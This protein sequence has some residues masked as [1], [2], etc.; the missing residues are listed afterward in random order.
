VQV[1]VR[2]SSGLYFRMKVSN[3]ELLKKSFL[4]TSS[5]TDN[6][7]KTSQE[8]TY[9]NSTTYPPNWTLLISWKAIDKQLNAQY[10]ATFSYLNLRYFQSTD[11]YNK[12][13]IKNYGAQ[14]LYF[15]E[16]FLL[17]WMYKILIICEACLQAVEHQ[18]D[19]LC[20]KNE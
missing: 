16:N 2:T 8:F 19:H 20:D 15:P 5:T 4:Y 10:R 6:W 14:I 18:F 12:V 9:Y 7:M 11:V 3:M 17:I 13:F 1:C